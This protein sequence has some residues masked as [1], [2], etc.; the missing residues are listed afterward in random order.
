MEAHSQTRAAFFE[1]ALFF[2]VEMQSIMQREIL[3]ACLQ[4][5]CMS[6]MLLHVYNAFA[7]L[8]KCHILMI[9]FLNNRCTEH[10]VIVLGPLEPLSLSLSCCLTLKIRS[11]QPLISNKCH[12]PSS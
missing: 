12:L 9:F 8:R 4:C 10:N 11:T 2:K 5:F 6:T 3:E 1:I 7:C